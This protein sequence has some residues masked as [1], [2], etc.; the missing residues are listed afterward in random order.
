MRFILV[1]LLVVITGCGG[2][3]IRKEFLALSA[4][5]PVLTKQS[6]A[7]RFRIQ[8]KDI[9]P[10]RL[11]DNPNVV[12]R[13]SDYSVAFER[14]AEWAVRPATVLTDM[15]ET[16]LS[17]TVECRAV[18]RRFSETMPDFIVSGNLVAV[19]DDHRKGKRY[20][21]LKVRMQLGKGRDDVLVL[22]K[23]FAESRQ[24]ALSAPYSEFASVLNG[25]MKDVT[26]S[27]A[28]EVSEALKAV[29]DA[30]DNST[31]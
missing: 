22:D 31:N 13:K 6:E 23:T 15:L 14:R 7:Y 10:G 27:F 4:D 24:L 30:T 9:E 16:E 20:V 2:N 28:G 11:A 17:S 26:K 12:V 18:R 1:A 21:V 19:E 29:R 25:M 3:R 8:V 5:T